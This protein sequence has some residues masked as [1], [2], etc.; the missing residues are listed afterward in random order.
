M[1]SKPIATLVGLALAALLPAVA[2]AA[3]EGKPQDPTEQVQKK[4]KH[5]KKHATTTRR[6]RR[7]DDSPLVP[8]SLTVPVRANKPAKGDKADKTEKIEK[9]EKTCMK[10]P[11]I[12]AAGGEQERFALAKCDGTPAPF[13]A[14]Y[15][16]LLAR[17]ASAQK[18]T[19]PVNELARS[20]GPELAPGIRRVDTRLLERLAVVAEHFGKKGKTTKIQLISGY[21][22]TSAG[23]YHSTA[24]ALDFR[25]EGIKN[26][27][28]VAFCK[29]LPDTGCGYYPNSLFV[30]M[31]VRDHGAGHV[32]WIDASGP[33]ESP[34]YV[35]E[36]PPPRDLLR[37]K[38]GDKKGAAESAVTRL[39][40]ELPPLP[41]DEHPPT[42]A[43]ITIPVR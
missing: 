32:S 41:P 40:R 31:D 9:T 22:P 29:T 34:R 8:V 30:H 38:K 6:A 16:S 18:P 12:V 4:P 36:W 26:E 39:D 25:I 2:H 5:H 21:R 10:A 19:E 1:S 14:E 37:E 13:A 15:L 23:S 20:S 33:G 28:V 24:R 35:A 7:S 17:P 27:E 11:V 3:T 43:A 42:A